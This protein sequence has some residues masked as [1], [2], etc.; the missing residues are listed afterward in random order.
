ML[1]F[2]LNAGLD[3]HRLDGASAHLPGDLAG[4]QGTSARATLRRA[5]PQHLVRESASRFAFFSFTVCMC[6]LFC[7]LAC[8]GDHGF[9]VTT[10]SERKGLEVLE[11]ARRQLDLNRPAQAAEGGGKGK[12]SGY[13]CVWVLFA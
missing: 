7:A 9:R 1:R 8:A 3:F 11:R 4:R 6:A 12:P 10:E 5:L 2:C 13:V